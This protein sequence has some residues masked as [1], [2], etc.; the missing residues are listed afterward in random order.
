MNIDNINIDSIE[1][2]DDREF[3]ALVAL[4]WNDYERDRE[5]LWEEL[6]ASNSS[7]KN[8]MEETQ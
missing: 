7:K 1:E 8:A 4:I 5:E 3:E 6:L 2:L